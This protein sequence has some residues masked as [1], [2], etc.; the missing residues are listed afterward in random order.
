MIYIYLKHGKQSHHCLRGFS[1][2]QM[3][4]MTIIHNFI[5]TRDDDTTA[6][7]R[8]YG[9][10]PPNFVDWLENELPDLATPRFRKNK[11]KTAMGS[12]LFLKMAA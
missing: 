6:C 4:A 5:I 8:L 9:V 11:F 1:K 7:E 10:K 3:M 12:D 2:E